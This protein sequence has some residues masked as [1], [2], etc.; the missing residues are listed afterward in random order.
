MD[1]FHVSIQSEGKD[2]F[3]RALSFFLDGHKSVVGYSISEEK[4]LIFYWSMTSLPK[5]VTKFPYDMNL[6]DAVA[7]AWGWLLKVAYPQPE[8]DHD[9]D[10]GKGFLIYN[11][12]WGHVDNEWAALVAILP[13]WAI[14]GK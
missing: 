3:V 14:Y 4:G 7:F 9:G 6:E 1:N 8:P 11:E 5:D 13:V 2:H 10:N 12:S